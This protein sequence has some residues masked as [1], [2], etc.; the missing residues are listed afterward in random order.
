MTLLLAPRFV[1][2][3]SDKLYRYL[4]SYALSSFLEVCHET[5]FQHDG[6]LAHFINVVCEYLD[7]TFGNRW[8]GHGGPITWPPHSPD[9][10]PLDF[11]LWGYMQGVVYETPLERQH[12]IV[13][14]I[15]VAAA[16]IQERQGSFK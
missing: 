14:R 12:D 2:G 10:T 8:I 1:D 3:C 5:W 15:A 9:L 4:T 13:A 6:A 16:T 7:E 11:F